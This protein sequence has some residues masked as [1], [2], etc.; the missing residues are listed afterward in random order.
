MT[1]LVVQSVRADAREMNMGQNHLTNPDGYESK[2]LKR[3]PGQTLCGKKPFDFMAVRGLPTC[4]RCKAHATAHGI[5][6]SNIVEAK[7]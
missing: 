5:L 4:P 6:P 3:V 7:E 1:W 2:R